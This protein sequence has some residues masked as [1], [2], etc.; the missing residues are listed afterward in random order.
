M[1]FTVFDAIAGLASGLAIRHANALAGAEQV[2]AA[3][4]AQYMLDNHFAGS[5][6]P[7]WFIQ[8]SALLTIVIATALVLR[9]AGASRALFVS[10]LVG[11]LHVFHA[12]PISA[13]GLLAITVALFLA[14]R[15][16]L[17]GGRHDGQ[18]MAM[19]GTSY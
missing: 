13:V 19:N 6:S 2:G 18:Q 14:H 1:S 16:G 9:S 4:T 17:I 12:G 10:M 3:S 8:A 15:E 11:V 7:V 5:I